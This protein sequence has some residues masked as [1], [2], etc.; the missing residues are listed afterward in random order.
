MA[1]DALRIYNTVTFKKNLQ[2]C[3]EK[4]LIHKL[5]PPPSLSPQLTPQSPPSILDVQAIEKTK[6]IA[7]RG[8]KRVSALSMERLVCMSASSDTNYARAWSMRLNA[9]P[10]F[11]PSPPFHH[12]RHHP[13]LNLS[14]AR[15]ICVSHYWEW[16]DVP[17]KCINSK[18]EEI[19]LLY[20]MFSLSH[21]NL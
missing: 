19:S 15:F 17:A 4:L 5:T 12:H 18:V 3:R 8:E 20:S 1:S 6:E 13:A 7:L 21:L 2:F 9:H 11:A 14:I 16:N 10:S